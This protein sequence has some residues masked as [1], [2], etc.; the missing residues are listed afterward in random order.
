MD[1][2]QRLA[3]FAGVLFQEP[4]TLAMIVNEEGNQ[5]DIA[6]MVVLDRE[7]PD[8]L[9]SALDCTPRDDE[10]AAAFAQRIAP[11]WG[12]PEFPL[13]AGDAWLERE[14]NEPTPE[15]QWGLAIG[16]WLRRQELFKALLDLTASPVLTWDELVDGLSERFFG[17]RR[18]G[19]HEARSQVVAAYFA[20]VAQARDLR[21]KR[22]RPKVP[23]HVRVPVECDHGFRWKMITQSGGT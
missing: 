12:A 16:D 22:A 4:F 15:K 23:T 11:L 14:I 17:L 1:R 13:T 18:V 20:L 7:V 8:V 9:P 21:S 2:L 6:E 3:D 5:V 19:D 10:T